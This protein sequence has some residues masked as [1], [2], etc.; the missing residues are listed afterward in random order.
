MATADVLHR[1]L[2]KL[3]EPI[4]SYLS[5]YVEDVAQDLEP[6]QDIIEDVIR[7]LLTSATLNDPTAAKVLEHVLAEIAEIVAQKMPSS[8]GDVMEEATGL[9]RLDRV[10][11]M[12]TSL[13]LSRTSGFES[14]TV[15]VGLGGSSKT[16]STVDVKKLEKQ[17]AKTRAKLVKRAQRDLYESSKL[18]ETSKQQESYEEMFLK[19]NPL[20]SAGA[21][22]K[23][24]DINLPSIDLNFGSN[25]ILS[26]ATLTLAGGRR[27]G[28]IGRNGVGKST[29]LR[30]MAL[31]E[32]PIPTS[33]SLL[34]VEQEIR[35]DDTT[36]LQAVL[37][38]DVWRERL[39][40][41]ERDLNEQLQKL[42]SSSQ[43]A[44][45][46][47][48]EAAKDAEGL[49]KGSAVDL[50]TRQR[51]VKRE[52]LSA[53]LGEV[54]AKLVEMEAETGPARAAAL[55]YGLGFDKEDQHKA[56]RAFSGGWRMRLSLAQ[57]LFV[58]PDLLMLGKSRGCTRSGEE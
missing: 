58:S 8:S 28:V 22:G 54:Q 53:R 46:A 33:I 45:A 44:V 20:E 27:Y 55:L 31:R 9:T 11:D 57:A 39:L 35:G 14:G 25:R 52:E 23:N 18:V 26:N 36:A 49:S 3:D 34:Y 4:V 7:P 37:K 21:R 12:R 38:A 41:E 16:R 6:S 48:A 19:V 2:P 51:E 47:A 17:E 29:L 32:L 5:G 42:E 13:G 56:T 24:K 50:P 40:Q 30:N 1:S 15:D 43:A 10:V